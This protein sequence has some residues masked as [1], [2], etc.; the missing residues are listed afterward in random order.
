[1]CCQI[2]LEYKMKDL[3]NWNLEAVEEWNIHILNELLKCGML[4]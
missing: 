4:V 2:L 3:K 1:M